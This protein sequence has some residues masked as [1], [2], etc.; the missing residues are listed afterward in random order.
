MTGHF[1]K[2][3]VMFLH[4]CVVASCTQSLRAVLSGAR[5]RMRSTSAGG[6]PCRGACGGVHSR[7]S[8]AAQSRYA[9]SMQPAVLE[10]ARPD[11]I[12]THS[13]DAFTSLVTRSWFEQAWDVLS[14]FLIATALIWTLPLL[15]GAAAALV[16]LLLRAL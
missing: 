10:S 2:R 1:R 4:R 14:D 5:A 9:S 15:L 6:P 12:A 7:T 3:H 16:R 11:R 8:N 13:R